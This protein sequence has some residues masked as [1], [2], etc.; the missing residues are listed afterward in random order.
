[1]F[2]EYIID[3]Q[4]RYEDWMEA[5]VFSTVRFSKEEFEEIVERAIRN[6]KAENCRVDCF[7]VAARILKYDDRFFVPQ[8]KQIA[9]V[10]NN[11]AFEGVI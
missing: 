9:I 11:G 3:A 10:K 5:S 8:T 2:Y 7:S 1:M 6:T 4:E